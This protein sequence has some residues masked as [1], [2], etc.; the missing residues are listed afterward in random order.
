MPPVTFLC[1][2]IDSNNLRL[3]GSKTSQAKSTWRTLYLWIDDIRSAS[4]K[5]LMLPSAYAGSGFWLNANSKRQAQHH[6][7]PNCGRKPAPSSWAEVSTSW[8]HSG[9]FGQDSGCPDHMCYRF[10]WWL[11]IAETDVF[12]PH[13]CTC[14]SHLQKTL[15]CIN[16]KLKLGGDIDLPHK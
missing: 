12:D 13:I 10:D 15:K 9:L 2:G 6:V 1:V 11:I 5:M 16:W 7:L 3:V 8:V 4:S 14:L